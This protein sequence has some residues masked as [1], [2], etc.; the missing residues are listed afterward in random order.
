MDRSCEISDMPCH[1]STSNEGRYMSLWKWWRYLP[2]IARQPGLSPLIYGKHSLLH[3]NTVVVQKVV[4]FVSRELPSA[5]SNRSCVRL[6]Y[7]NGKFAVYLL[8][9]DNNT[10]LF[11]DTCVLEKALYCACRWSLNSWNTCWEPILIFTLSFSNKLGRGTYKLNNQIWILNVLVNTMWV[12]K[13]LL[14]NKKKL[15]GHDALFNYKSKASFATQKALLT[16][17]DAFQFV[18]LDI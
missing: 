1:L 17:T 7:N 5:H 15:R 13:I 4:N 14:S 3:R 11:C 2:L 9:Q 8:H 16:S 12:A 18:T 10:K 6:W